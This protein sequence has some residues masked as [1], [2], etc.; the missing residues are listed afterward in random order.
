MR[1]SQNSRKLLF[2]HL[3]DR[4]SELPLFDF[5]FLSLVL[6]RALRWLS[7]RSTATEHFRA[8]MDFTWLGGLIFGGDQRI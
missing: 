7:G 3:F 1:G 5:Y 4:Y 6:F 8:I 2:L